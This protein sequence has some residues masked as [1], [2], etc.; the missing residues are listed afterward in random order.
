MLRNEALPG[1]TV[2]ATEHSVIGGASH[3]VAAA[4]E[5]ASWADA[6][7]RV[8]GAVQGGLSRK[9]AGNGQENERENVDA[10]TPNN[11]TDGNGERAVK[12]GQGGN[13][14]WADIRELFVHP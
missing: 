6:I 8:W 2:C 1:R 5:S 10:A 7:R 3:S 13:D 11:R 14:G 12:D 4:A 9:L